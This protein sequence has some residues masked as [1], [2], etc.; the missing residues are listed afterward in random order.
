MSLHRL[1][2]ITLGVPNVKETAAY[3]EEFGLAPV[4]EGTRFATRDGGEQLTIVEAPAR[5][6]V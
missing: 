3:Y 4:G 2:S 5:R 6:L 1:T